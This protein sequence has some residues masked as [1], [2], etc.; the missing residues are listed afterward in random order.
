MIKVSIILG[1]Y[2]RIDFLKSTIYSVRNNNI[3]FDF[4]IIVVDGGSTDGSLKWLIEQKDIITITQHNRGQFNGKIIE[5]KSWGYFMNLGFKCAS[6]KYILMISDDCLMLPDSVNNGVNQFEKLINSGKKIGAIA[7]Y[8]RNW[9]E[10]C[11]Y[12]VGLAFG[13]IFVNHGLYLRQALVDVD[14]INEVDYSFYH[15]DGDLSL[16]I[17]KKGYEIVDAEASFIEH[18][19]HANLKIR[20][21]NEETQKND[22]NTYFE[23][24]SNIEF[25]GKKYQG[26]WIYKSFLDKSKTYKNFPKRTLISFFIKNKLRV[27]KTK[28]KR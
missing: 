2:N 10:M 25:S 26:D 1:S 13:K 20:K 28:I 21:S 24:W 6:G 22:W 27:I 15:G 12:W 4:E 14:W 3:L 9:P 7:F 5:R 19:S 11:N 17:W 16:K 23:K 8:W 18:F